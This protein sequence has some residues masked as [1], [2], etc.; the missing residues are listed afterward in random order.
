MW[1]LCGLGSN[2]EPEKNISK[3]LT[4]LLSKLS[5]IWVSEIIRTA[6]VGIQTEHYFLNALVA[7]WSPEDSQALKERLNKIE[8]DLGR[9]RNDPDRSRKD[10][11]IDID[12]LEHT[13]RPW[14]KGQTISE[15]YF[16]NL[17]EG[18]PDLHETPVLI[19]FN[20]HSLGK[21]PATI[22]RTSDT[23]YVIIERS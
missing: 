15:D 13:N 21:V 5:W 18:R 11:T 23:E 9:D 10:H 20:G 14:F 19:Q 16:R 8:K 22:H 4:H 3:A 17:F 12:I 7:F 6:P 1:Y 2:I